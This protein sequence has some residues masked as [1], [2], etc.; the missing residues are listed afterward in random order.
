M[1]YTGKIVKEF[2]PDENSTRKSEGAFL[3][4]SDGVVY[5]VFSHYRLSREDGGACDLAL[6]VS[7]DDGKTFSDEKVIL[8]CDECDAK[9]IMSVSMLEMQ[10]GS[11]GVFYLK[12]SGNTDCRMFMRRTKDFTSFSDEVAVISD[13]GYSVVNN[14]KALRLKDGSIIVPAAFCDTGA[15]PKDITHENLT[16][17]VM[18]PAVAVFWKSTDD[19]KTFFKAGKTEMPHKIFTT[20]LQE[21]VCAELDD[22]RLVAYF[23]NNSGRQYVAFSSDGA[24]SWTVPEPSEF[25]SPPSPLSL[26][27]LSD[28]TFFAVYNPI[29]LFYKRSETVGEKRAWTGARTPLVA[30][31]SKDGIKDFA[32]ESE[33]ETDR[34]RG[35]C[36]CA[37]CETPDALLLAYCAG[38]E[39]DGSTLARTRIRRIEK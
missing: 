21:P 38:G 33:L 4:K 20:G 9:N 14:D 2:I 23:R 28:G 30:A 6:S 1:K 12:K 3:R 29:P 22:G 25:T 19:G 34:E 17:R 7:T 15:V 39:T 18:P 11:I 31:V 10:D 36:Y 26:K 5:F 16:E 37:V 13:A 35:F 8:T 24:A 32:V 27:R